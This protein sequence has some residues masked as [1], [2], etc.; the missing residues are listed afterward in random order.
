MIRRIRA[1][2]QGPPGPQPSPL[3]RADRALPPG[4]PWVGGHVEAMTLS[5]LRF[6]LL[7]GSPG[8]AAGDHRRPG[9]VQ[10]QQFPLSQF[11]RP[12]IQGQGCSRVSLP[13]EAPG[14]SLRWLSHPWGSGSSLATRPTPPSLCLCLTPAPGAS[15]SLFPI[16]TQVIDLEPLD[17]PG[18]SS[19]ESLT[20]GSMQTPLFQT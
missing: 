10:L 2:R 20:F 8:V 1:S 5:G 7:S 14:K 9:D 12:D 11:W 18:M 19:P 17:H 16:R 3:P 6:C 15:I 13:L 4:E